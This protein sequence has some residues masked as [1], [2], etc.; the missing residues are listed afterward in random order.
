M[1]WSCPYGDNRP[2]HDSGIDQII[3]LREHRMTHWLQCYEGEAHGFMTTCEKGPGLDWSQVRCP[4]TWVRSKRS[5]LG[6]VFQEGDKHAH[7]CC[8]WRDSSTFEEP[9]RWPCRSLFSC[10]GKLRWG[11]VGTG[12]CCYMGL[13]C[14]ELQDH[15]RSCTL[16]WEPALDLN[17]VSIRLGFPEKHNQHNPCIYYPR[18]LRVA[19]WR[20]RAADAL[21]PA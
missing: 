5:R 3:M 20:P 12:E 2:L 1:W 15:T 13:G 19:N 16:C 6:E 8:G 10:H 11:G 7:S 18:S 4:L 21:K 14:G 9:Q 17:A